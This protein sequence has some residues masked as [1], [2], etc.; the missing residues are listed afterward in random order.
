MLKEKEW[1][2]SRG[3]RIDQAYSTL[4]ELIVLGRLSP[5][6]RIIETEVA[7][8]LG[9]SR[10]PV[11]AA[12]QRLHQ[13]GYVQ[14]NG[15]GQQARMSVTPLTEADAR[16]L[17][18]IVAQLEGLASRW[19]AERA[20]NRGDMVTRLRDLNDDLAHA[21]A[22]ADVDEMLAIDQALHRAIVEAAAGPRLGALHDSFKPQI[23]RYGR[24]YV[25][26]FAD[27]F[28]RAVEE[29]EALI[30]AIDAGLGSIADTAMRRNWHNS[31]ERLCA[32]IRKNGGRGNWQ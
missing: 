29:H 28:E 32:L 5:G 16:E 20:E 13:E 30:E 4:R 12:L 6:S 9:V 25:N 7:A 14:M 3:D 8:R 10:T 31:T 19:V 17:F 2:G 27:D 1:A 26:A 21:G 22:R 15:H 18:A 23:E 11:R 24:L